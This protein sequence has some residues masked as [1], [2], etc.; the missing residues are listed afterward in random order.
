[1]ICIIQPFDPNGADEADRITRGLVESNRRAVGHRDLV[2]VGL[3]TYDE[4]VGCWAAFG[5]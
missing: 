3:A 1:M 2:P 4:G 5:A